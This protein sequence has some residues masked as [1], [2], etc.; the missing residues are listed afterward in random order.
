MKTLTKIKK[1]QSKLD[2]KI[3]GLI[4]FSFILLMVITVIIIREPKNS[5]RMHLFKVPVFSALIKE[6]NET[7]FR[8]KMTEL[9]LKKPSPE[10]LVK[11]IFD[12]DRQS[13]GALNDYIKFYELV[14]KYFPDTGEAYGLIGYC[15]F[16]SGEYQKAKEFFIQANQ[17][18]PDHFWFIFNLVMVSL[19]MNNVE[20]AKVYLQS[21][22]QLNYNAFEKTLQSISESIIYQDVLSR[23][24][25]ASVDYLRN[26]LVQGYQTMDQMKKNS[27]RLSEFIKQNNIELRLF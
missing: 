16:Y 22:D 27:Q 14:S 12:V 23:V 18:M 9:N 7:Y 13:P 17:L 3:Y 15:Y 1:V 5:V 2:P 25:G 20:E 21:A 11:F 24:E 19:K 8:A 6:R 4:V 26:N 10:Y